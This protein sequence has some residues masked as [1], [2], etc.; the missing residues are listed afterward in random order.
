MFSK[1]FFLAIGTAILLLI[2]AGY[3]AAQMSS[4]DLDPTTYKDHNE[5]L[6]DIAAK[7]PEF[8]GVYVSDD[9]TTLNVYMTGNTTDQTKQRKAK[10][11]IEDLLDAKPGMRLNVIIGDYSI[12]QLSTWYK[13]LQSQGVWDKSGVVTTDLNEGEN[14]IYVG[15][16]NQSDIAGVQELLDELDIPRAAVMI[17]VE[18]L[19]TPKLHTIL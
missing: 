9:G 14:R 15:V 1:K 10:E 16:T 11:A 6:E 13:T 7:V 5:L 8:G 18:P 3:A 12:D 17:E 19:E 4:N 2:G